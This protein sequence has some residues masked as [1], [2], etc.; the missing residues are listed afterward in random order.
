[1]ALLG[2]GAA[3]MTSSGM[4]IIG[5]TL[6]G[7]LKNRAIA[8][9]GG[10]QGIGFGLGLVCAGFLCDLHRGWRWIFVVQACLGAIF[11]LLGW[12]SVPAE[13]ERYNR[14]LDLPGASLCVVSLLLL[15]FSLSH[16]QNVGWKVPYIPALF[17]LS[18]VLLAAFIYW[19]H[20]AE[21]RGDSVLLKIGMF[22]NKQLCAFFVLM[23]AM[24][25]NFNVLQYLSTVYFQNVQ[26]LSP[27]KTAIRF[28]PEAIAD[29]VVNVSTG[30]IIEHIPGQWLNMFGILTSMTASVL[31]AII[32]PAVSF[33]RNAFWVTVLMTGADTI[34]TVGSLYVLTSMD[35][36][37]QALAGGLFL[38]FTR[39]ATSIGLAVSS[40]VAT[41]VSRHQVLPSSLLRGYHAAGWVCFAA[42]CVGLAVNVGALWGIG[43]LVAEEREEL[44][45]KA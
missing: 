43:L 45:E 25:W 20:I 36:Q 34:Y 28:I 26:G 14:A 24:W 41:A 27:V 35:A 37:S 7:K 4:G 5:G 31:F 40:A 11:V 18:L 15:T 16:S 33:W 29:F 38:T 44:S 9:V 30:W 1:M 3:M 19:E 32:N 23:F 13:G 42:S 39:L 22:K 8:I 2:I 12:A 6:E 10:G 21:K 17:A